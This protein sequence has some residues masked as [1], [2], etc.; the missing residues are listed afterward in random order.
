MRALLQVKRIVGLDICPQE[1]T[2]LAG[3]GTAF[4]ETEVDTQ[5]AEERHVEAHIIKDALR[6]ATAAP[7]RS[8]CSS[9][10]F[11]VYGSF[12]GRVVE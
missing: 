5:E 9:R 8:C 2:I 3:A 1:P 6:R 12:S 11:A 7:H 4:A 10:L